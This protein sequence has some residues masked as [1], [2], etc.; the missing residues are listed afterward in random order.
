MPSGTAHVN[1][2]SPGTQNNVPNLDPEL[3]LYAAGREVGSHPRINLNGATLPR[4]GSAISTPRRVWERGPTCVLHKPKLPVGA[5]STEGG[6]REDIRRSTIKGWRSGRE[7]AK[8][9]QVK[10]R[11]V[12][13]H[14]SP[15]AVARFPGSPGEKQRTCWRGSWFSSQ[16]NGV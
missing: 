4:R 5:T 12:K 8:H 3:E 1:E 16:P 7:R 13:T 10:L 6:S 14:E 2:C 11:K 9:K 15:V